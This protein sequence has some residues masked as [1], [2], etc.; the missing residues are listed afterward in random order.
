MGD[1]RMRE[2]QGLFFWGFLIVFGVVMYLVVPSSKDEAG[3]FAMIVVMLTS[4]GSTLDSIFTSLSKLV[5]REWPLLAD[6]LPSP[7]AM[8][9]G[10]LTMVSFA[11]LRNLPL[12]LQRDRSVSSVVAA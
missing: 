10:S 1:L 12:L 7:K 5:A 2:F 3:F 8:T 6:R 11:L 4:A 9:V